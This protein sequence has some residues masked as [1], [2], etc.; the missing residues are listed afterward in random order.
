MV[1]KGQTLS[2]S[3]RVGE[4]PVRVIAFMMHGGERK[5]QITFDDFHYRVPY[6]TLMDAANLLSVPG[7][8][9][10]VDYARK[11]EFAS[12]QKSIVDKVFPYPASVDAV[13]KG[14]GLILATDDAG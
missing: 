12:K 1:D 4:K 2:V 7:L 11:K 6:K 5:F 8:I 9:N 3:V 13:I 10:A 14:F